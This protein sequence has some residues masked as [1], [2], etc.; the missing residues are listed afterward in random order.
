MKQPLLFLLLI[1]LALSL[2][3]EEF[4]ALKERILSLEQAAQ[5]DK[6]ENKL[7]KKEVL[8]LRIKVSNLEYKNNNEQS[9]SEVL[10]S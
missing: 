3:D 2:F 7:L 6:S 9:L 5:E 8:D 4:E 10:N 1:P